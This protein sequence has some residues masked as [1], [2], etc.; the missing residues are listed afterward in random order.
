MATDTCMENMIPVEFVE[1]IK[2]AQKRKEQGWT[3]SNKVFR[4]AVN[5]RINELNEL[6]SRE[7]NSVKASNLEAMLKSLNPKRFNEGTLVFGLQHQS[8][9]KVMY[10]QLKRRD[11]IFAVLFRMNML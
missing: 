5:L 8:V 2:D 10:E 4:E 11:M 3:L 9:Q 1:T 6:I 7:L